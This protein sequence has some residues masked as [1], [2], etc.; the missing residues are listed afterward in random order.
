MNN[1]DKYDLFNAIQE[2]LKNDKDFAEKF[3]SV[4]SEAIF[5]TS[6]LAHVKDI[7]L[8]DKCLFKLPPSPPTPIKAQ[9][10]T[11]KFGIKVTDNK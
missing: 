10:I 8:G 6:K 2:K 11:E 9:T 7:E 4:I 5:S 3:Y 1:E